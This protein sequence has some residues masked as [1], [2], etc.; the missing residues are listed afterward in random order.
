MKDSLIKAVLLSSIV[1]S[2]AP[3]GSNPSSSLNSSTVS[4]S[5]STSVPNLLAKGAT[6]LIL[7]S[8]IYH[9]LQII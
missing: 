3:K 1:S 7:K 9:L 8:K 2:C 5:L 4:T 6:S